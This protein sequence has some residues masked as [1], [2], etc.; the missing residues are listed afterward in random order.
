MSLYNE[1]SAILIRLSD[2]QN[3]SLSQSES[4]LKSLIFPA[5][6]SAPAVARKSSPTQLYALLIE[7][8]KWSPILKEIVERSGLL[9]QEKKLTPQLAL[10]LTHDLLLAKRGIAAASSHPLRQAVE[11]HKARLG[12][13]FV[14]ARLRR[15][16]ASIEALR[17]LLEREAKERDEGAEGDESVEGNVKRWPHPRWV[18]INTLRTSTT[19]QLH[20]TFA[21]Y[22][23]APLFEILAAGSHLPFSTTASRASK[24]CHQDLHIPD[25]LALPAGTDITKWRAYREGKLIL[26]DKASCFPAYLL[27]YRPS[28]DQNGGVLDACAAPG[29]KTSHVAALVESYANSQSIKGQPP[30]IYACERDSSRAETLQRMMKVAGCDGRTRGD[31]NMPSVKVLAGQDFLK[32]DPNT[33]PWKEVRAILLDP[34]C[35]GSGIVDRDEKPLDFT[36]P[37]QTGTSKADEPSRKRKRKRKIKEEANGMHNGVTTNG[38]RYKPISNDMPSANPT[39]ASAIENEPIVE[40][41][42]NEQA[43]KT[44]LASLAA[45]QTKM[46]VHAFCFPSASRITYS[47]CSIYDEE[48]ESVIVAALSSSIAKEKGW[49]VLRRE[50][51]VE[52]LKR[53]NTRGNLQ[54]CVQT[55]GEDQDGNNGGLNAKEI[56]E[57]CIRC[58]KFTAEG[59]HGFFVVGFARDIDTEKQSYENA[60][61]QDDVHRNEETAIDWEGFGD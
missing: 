37:E 44:R 49:R 15:G 40:A 52:G 16:C 38:D 14:K 48:N 60:D 47:T 21:P 56:A 6:S 19:E 25:L 4:S 61:R 23:P 22:L 20:S 58:E 53:W 27:D 5:P 42:S 35:S 59:T 18:R 55:H 10:L 45:L 3:K 29:N 36:L 8:S 7:A 31:R 12:A 54:A 41:S 32:L 39:P 13:E 11:R 46:L 24:I 43:L 51:Q 50:E 26:Q 33:K 34:S 57:A 9:D 30:R 1:A 2:F 28:G 17:G